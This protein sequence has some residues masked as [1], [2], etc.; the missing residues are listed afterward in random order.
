MP[1][2][3]IIRKFENTFF[4]MT[5]SEVEIRA[6]IKV[7]NSY[8]LECDANGN[9]ADGNNDGVLQNR[10]LICRIPDHKHDID[11]STLNENCL[12]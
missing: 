4:R 2:A 3:P 7:K 12:Q 10:T 11:L 5:D 1:E 6:G 8:W 9:I